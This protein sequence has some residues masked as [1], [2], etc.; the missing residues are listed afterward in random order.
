MLW[1]TFGKFIEFYQLFFFNSIPKLNWFSSMESI[2][3][4]F[5]TQNSNFLDFFNGFL[6]MFWNWKRFFFP[7]SEANFK[8]AGGSSQT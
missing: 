1:P 7:I 8:L 5:F 2:I 6:L 3:F 4:L